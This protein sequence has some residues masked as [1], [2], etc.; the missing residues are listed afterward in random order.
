MNIPGAQQG[1]RTANAGLTPRGGVHYHTASTS[2]HETIAITVD[3]RSNI[4][5]V[6]ASHNLTC[7]LP[8]VAEAGGMMFFFYLVTA[9]GANCVITDAGDDLDFNDATLADENDRCI[10]I[11]DG[12][13][14]FC[15]D[16]GTTAPA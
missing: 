8:P 1:Q 7:T 10:L 13:H 2:A 12:I 14:W 5:V 4:L 3:Q 6:D 11:S 9:G 15:I 16:A